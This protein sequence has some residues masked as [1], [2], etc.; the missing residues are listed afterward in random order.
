M[1]RAP[2]RR[3]VRFPVR[4]SGSVAGLVLAVLALSTGVAGA[5]QPPPAD[6]AARFEEDERL[7]VVDLPV[8]FTHDGFREWATDRAPLFPTP[9]DFSVRIDGVETPIVS[10]GREDPGEVVLWFLADRSTTALLQRSALE[11]ADQAEDLVALGPVTVVLAD[12][13]P[14]ILGPA[15]SSPDVLRTRLGDLSRS[16]EGRDEL[17]QL[18]HEVRAEVRR[19]EAGEGTTGLDADELEE[20]AAREEARI[21]RT[22]HDRLITWVADRE[23]TGT[24][25]VLVLVAGSA[26]GRRPEQEEAVVSLGRLLAAYGWTLVAAHPTPEEPLRDGWTIGKW[27]SAGYGSEQRVV[28]DPAT[29]EEDHETLVGWRW[30]RESHRDPDRAEA[31]LAL[32]TALE[33]QGNAEEAAETY[34]E[35]LYRFAGHRDTA[36]RQAVALVGLARVLDEAGESQEARVALRLARGIDADVV[37]R[38]AGPS[39]DVDDPV[40]SARTLADATGGS[41]VAGREELS[42]ALAA[43]GQRV[44]VSVQ[45]EGWPD[46]RARPVDVE[47]SGIWRD[48]AYPRWVRSSIPITVAAARLRLA[49]AGEGSEGPVELRVE[50]SADDTL[51]WRLDLGGLGEAVGPRGARFRV[52]TLERDGDEI[53]EGPETRLEE[54]RAELGAGARRGTV[55]W[56]GFAGGALAILVEELVTGAWGLAVV[57]G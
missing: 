48:P 27:R 40:A 49:L 3:V 46:G 54:P 38:E 6:G 12:P 45:I 41:V 57:D 33:G 22:A 55:A 20:S 1:S 35:S 53:A 17:L 23:R 37:D 51:E 44:R 18:R 25:R 28:R 50:R 9:D 32:A 47:L 15:E 19:I 11:L 36:A 4:S 5:T 26:D 24:R 56:G 13:R 42:S 31:L 43:L 29:G 52:T 39:L 2:F 34:R 8:G 14:T 10:V 16:A 30:K 7:T 21:V